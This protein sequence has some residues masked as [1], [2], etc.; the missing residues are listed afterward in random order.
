MD[1]TDPPMDFHGTRQLRAATIAR[2][3]Y[4]QMLPQM[5]ASQRE[6]AI[7]LWKSE[8]IHEPQ[9][10]ERIV[11]TTYWVIGSEKLWIARLYAI[12]F[13][14]VGGVALYDL[15]RRMTNEDGGLFS[16][17]LYL[18][19]PFGVSASRSFQPDPFMVMWILIAAWSLY[20]WSE[21]PT[22]KWAIL[23]GIIGG[24]AILI[25]S[26]A[27]IMV[28]M[29]AVLTVFTTLGYRNIIKNRQ[30]WV[31]AGLMLFLPVLYALSIG[32]SSS[33]YI[34][35][36]ILDT[37]GLLAQPRFYF[38]WLKVLTGILDFS[39]LLVAA[40]AVALLKPRGRAIGLGLW[41]GFIL[42]GLA[43]P[44]QISTH[45]YHNLM[46]IPTVSLS[47]APMA[48]LVFGKVAE[49]KLIWQG[50]FLSVAILA[51][52]HQTWVSRNALLSVDY[53]A[54]AKAWQAMGEALPEDGEM[55]ALT[56]D[57]GRRL[58]YYGQRVVRTWPLRM[59]FEVMAARGE[60]YDG[61]FEAL[62]FE[63]TSGADYFLI[64][65]FSELDQQPEL[66]N[67]LYDNYPILMQGDGYLLFDLRGGP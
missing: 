54:E 65:L 12:L 41:A 67:H 2:G 10:F 60:P 35:F 28:G 47:L 46:I 24:F 58:R 64:N 52:A 49:E 37:R 38:Q 20:R 7:A 15:S 8:D 36:W 33:G 63:Q 9:I 29:M 1:L 11:A 34:Q 40:A 66:K 30:V 22:W 43:M 5:D 31:M 23:S 53:R 26:V 42:F 50:F 57:Y 17:A 19:T 44:F 16:L 18:V 6:N 51:I 48:A 62:F 25:K 3:M 27:V 14:L 21:T 39:L 55:I 45:D 4:Y 61:N 59:D 56:H 13:W 32:E